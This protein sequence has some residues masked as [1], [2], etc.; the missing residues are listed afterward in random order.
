VGHVCRTGLFAPGLLDAATERLARIRERYVW[1]PAESV[2][3]HN[4]PI[5]SNVLFDGER[6]WLIDWESA[7]RNDPLVD[8]AIMLD[9]LARSPELEVALLRAWLGHAP[10]E[11]I[12]ARLSLIR[13][14][15]RLYYAGVLL[16]ASAAA[17]GAMR[18][19]DLSAPTVPEFQLAIREGRLKP[20]ASETKH[21]LGKMFVAAFFFGVAPPGLGAAV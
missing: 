12:C 6:L 15:T 16:S 8:V 1:D 7:Y 9:N 19:D 10:D 5:P 13:A 14:F 4:D 20:G 21:V 11:T 18:D 3:S 2:S 17:L